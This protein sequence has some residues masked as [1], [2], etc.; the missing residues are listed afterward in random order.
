M[1]FDEQ[2]IPEEPV[3]SIPDVPVQNISEEPVQQSADTTKSARELWM[4]IVRLLLLLLWT[5]VKKFIKVT[6]KSICFCIA[7]AKLCATSA[8]NW[9][10]DKSTQEKVRAIKIKTRYW[11]RE[12]WKYTKRGCKALWRWT[13]IASKAVVKYS[14]ITARL[15]WKGLV[16]LCI[17]F[18]QLIIH[19]KPMLI[20]W[21]KAT[22]RGYK[23]L[24][25]YLQQMRR[26]IKL[27]KIVQQRRYATFKRNG[28]TKK[29]LENT[30]KSLK[31]SVQSYME[32]EQN[33][34]APDAITEDDIIEARFEELEQTNR[35]HIIGKKIFSSMKNIVEEK[36]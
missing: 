28:G 27:K 12:G 25:F 4:E 18:V 15:I 7:F 26:G 2:N 3:Q 11:C 23:L 22:Q 24:R 36:E 17:N 1:D 20:R 6:Y 13:V 34:A 10:Q 16:W 33:E 35:A 19:T 31:S 21:G 29:W 32:E 30:S 5:I 9:W 8:K 14:V